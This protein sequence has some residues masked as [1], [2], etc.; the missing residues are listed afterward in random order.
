M[1]PLCLIKKKVKLSVLNTTHYAMKAYG[2]MDVWTHIFLT[3]ALVGGEWSVSAPAALPQNPRPQWIGGWM[4]SRAVLDDAEKRKF[5]TQLGLELRLL[6]F[7][8]SLS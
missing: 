1:L 3:T 7:A 8:C 2:G 5:L 4:G 6:H